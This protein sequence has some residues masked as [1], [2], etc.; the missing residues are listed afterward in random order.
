MP[1]VVGRRRPPGRSSRAIRTRQVSNWI[2]LS[3]PL[4]LLVAR[5]GRCDLSPGP[6]GIILAKNW[7]RSFPRVRNRAM[8]IGDVVLLGIS[9]EH[10][11]GR[12][13]L[14]EHEARH[15]GQYAWCLGP[16]FFLPAYGLA[17]AWSWLHTRNPALRNV[18]EVRAGLV[19]GGY[20][21]E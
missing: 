19:E 15:C 18:F 17:S 4:G 3:T 9:D 12:A 8:T 5:Y 21:D 6:Y 10:L 20:R 1:I 11:A 2:N 14:L 7:S 13:H 16:L